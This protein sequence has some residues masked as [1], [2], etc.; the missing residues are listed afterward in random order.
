MNEGVTFFQDAL[1]KTLSNAGVMGVGIWW[2]T[3]Y[4]IPQLQKERQQS[5][6]AFERQMEK[7]RITHVGINDKLLKAMEDERTMHKDTRDLILKMYE[8]LFEQIGG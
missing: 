6:E 5:I 8:K 4:L 2:L 1:V 7:E 3:Q